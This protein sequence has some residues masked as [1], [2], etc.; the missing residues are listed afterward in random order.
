MYFARSAGLT[1]IIYFLTNIPEEPTLAAAAS[2]SSLPSVPSIPQV[3][4][5]SEYS[6]ASW[7]KYDRENPRLNEKHNKDSQ[8][9]CYSWRLV[10]FVASILLVLSRIK[11]GL[12]P[13]HVRLSPPPPPIRASPRSENRWNFLINFAYI[14]ILSLVFQT[15]VMS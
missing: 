9:S 2:Q 13:P 1:T 11:K 3:G 6:V 7:T 8:V 15:E 4:F 10:G 12:V 14:S 5:V